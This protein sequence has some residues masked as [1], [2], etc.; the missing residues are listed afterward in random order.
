MNGM[1]LRCIS[2]TMSESLLEIDLSNSMVDSQKIEILTSHL[3]NLQILRLN[4][5]PKLDAPSMA[6]I[7]KMAGSSL[8]E[9]FVSD[10]IQ[11]RIEPLLYMSGAAYSADERKPFKNQFNH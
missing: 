9:L 3:N 8:L 4:K 11:F 5:C 6:I 2:M 7:T 10:C 1:V